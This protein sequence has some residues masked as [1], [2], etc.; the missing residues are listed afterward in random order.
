[1]GSD[2]AGDGKKIEER[3]FISNSRTEEI[4]SGAP[5]YREI[6]EIRRIV[7]CESGNTSRKMCASRRKLINGPR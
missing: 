7:R 6:P 4:N 1:M 2:K 3:M 5:V